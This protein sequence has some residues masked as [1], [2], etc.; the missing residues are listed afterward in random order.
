MQVELLLNPAF[1]VESDREGA[2]S[3]VIV[4]KTS[5]DGTSPF[6]SIVPFMALTDKNR[7]EC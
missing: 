5:T 3:E 1:L 6:R 2:G 4:P 7:L